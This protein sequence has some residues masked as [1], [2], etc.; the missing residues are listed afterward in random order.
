VG[1][2][3]LGDNSKVLRKWANTAICFAVIGFGL[4][5][6]L[7][8][9]EDRWVRTRPYHPDLVHGYVFRAESHGA[10]FFVNQN[11]HL[12]SETAIWGGVLFVLLAF[13]TGFIGFL[14]EQRAIRNSTD[15]E[16]PQRS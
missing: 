8:V 14:L 4:L 12:I 5:L 13:V 10:I 16:P 1:E 15:E 7:F 11:E 6:L 2:A 9:L 3:Y